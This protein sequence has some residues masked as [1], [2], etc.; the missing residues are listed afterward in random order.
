MQWNGGYRENVQTFVNNIDTSDWPGSHRE[1][2]YEALTNVI[3]RHAR[4]RKLMR[5]TEPDLS[6][7]EIR[8]GLSAVVVV[9]L[10]EPTFAN[11]AV[12]HLVSRQVKRAVQDL[13]EHHMT[14]WFEANPVAADAVTDKA[15]C[16]ADN[17][18]MPMRSFCR[19]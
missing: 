17:A 10:A 1:S 3:S 2:F 9:R 11:A 14:R 12:P 19:G 15:I 4:D 5:D 8:E 13:C 16:A 18:R 6:V 7:D